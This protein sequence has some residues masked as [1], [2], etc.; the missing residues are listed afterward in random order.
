MKQT[1]QQK[2]QSTF[3]SWWFCRFASMKLIL[4]S[5]YCQVVLVEFSVL[6]ELDS[7]S[8]C[9]IF[10]L[11]CVIAPFPGYSTVGICGHKQVWEQSHHHC[12]LVNRNVLDHVER[13]GQGSNILATTN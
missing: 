8:N 13:T 2:C 1:L 7:F 12:E 5:S 11:S 3:A 10:K 9:T 4:Q 6:L